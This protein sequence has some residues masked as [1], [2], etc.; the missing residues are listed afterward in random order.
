MS[1]MIVDNAC[2]C[3]TTKATAKEASAYRVAFDYKV[4]SRRCSDA[5][6][7]RTMP[8]TWRHARPALRATHMGK[9]YRH[10]ANEWGES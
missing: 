4:A 5:C 6:G 3:D 7:R 2:M 8:H 1:V 9:I 10:V